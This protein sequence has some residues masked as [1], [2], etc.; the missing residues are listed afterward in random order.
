MPEKGALPVFEERGYR[1]GKCPKCGS[2]FW[3]RD[4][5]SDACGDTPCVEY[6]F[7]GDP[8]I[9]KRHDLDSMREAYLSFF[10]KDHKRVGRYPVVARWRN[11][12]FL[13]NASIYDFQP[14][15]TS[16]E[17]PAP[18]NPL[19]ISQPCI[20]MVD[21]DSVGKSGRHTSNFEMMAHHAFNYPDKEVYWDDQTVR[22]CMDLL[23]SLGIDE[24]KVVYKEN[25]WVGGGNA[26]HALE[27]MVDGLELATLVFMNY[28]ADLKGETEIKGGRY[29]PMDIRIVDTG[30]GLE[31][32]VWASK[33]TPTVYEAIYPDVVKKVFDM[34]SVEPVTDRYPELGME[35]ARAAGIINVDSGASL[36]KLRGELVARL[37]SKGINTSIEELT[38]IM[39]PVEMAYS[40]VDHSRCLALMLYDEMIPSNVKAGYLVRLV[41]RKALRHMEQLGLDTDLADLILMHTDNMSSFAKLKKKEDFVRKVIELETDRYKDTASKAGKLVSKHKKELSAGGETG[42][43]TL[44]KLYDTYGLH[45]S[46]VKKAS[47][48]KGLDVEVPDGFEAMVAEQHLKS[49]P[50]EGVPA[51]PKW[52]IDVQGAIER[53][54]LPETKTGYYDDVHGTDFE[55]VVLFA[56]DGVVVLDQ[57]LFY[58]EGGGQPPDGGSLITPTGSLYVTD[59]QKVGNVILH[60]VD[61]K[62]PK[63]GE[64][65]KGRI[66]RELRLAHMRHHTGTHVVLASAREVLGPHIWQ[67]GAQKGHEEARIDVTH[68]SKI[69]G[70]EKKRIEFLANEAV[71]RGIPI[72]KTV[73]KREEAE[74]KYGFRL[75]QGGAP[76]GRHVRI[77]RIGE[78]DVQGCGGTHLDNTGDIGMIKVKRTERIQ[79][80]VVRIEFSTGMAAVKNIQNMETILETSSQILSVPAYQLPRTVQRFF[81]E[82]KQLNKEVKELRKGS[83]DPVRML[84]QAEEVGGTKVVAAKVDL[85]VNEMIPVAKELTSGASCVVI[86]VSSEE[87]G[88]GN[89]LVGRS[90]DVDLDAREVVD[91]AA[92]I[93][94]GK[95]GGRPVL[96]QG[97]G[98]NGGQAEAA[99]ERAKEMVLEALR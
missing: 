95:G 57:T 68:F 2:V 77:V 15:V 19:S 78:L 10:D 83:L 17:V 73:L 58:P 74:K 88:G 43:R 3:S 86:L 12:V 67:A 89:I 39:E 79:D 64:I 44:V 28:R 59:V 8:P 30:Y 6:T 32:F 7:I 34:A 93:L 47:S 56:G 92:E 48:E 50:E 99:L 91:Q 27:V 71:L 65:V 5:A 87:G 26:G 98:P 84:D 4:G 22:Y 97:G 82:W 40:V 13:V 63:V 9:G 41:L 46:L 24:T 90:E 80:G 49:T 20:R 18:E 37:R 52:I 54:R 53:Q 61:G 11:D 29:S 81:N 85:K 75:Y 72:E 14:H 45:P 33:G 1:K 38:T 62:L 60:K 55:A 36:A 96:A 25:P 21:L 16:G 66:D 42:L 31:R 23:S 51:T 70:E 35:W 69:T 76:A 94:G